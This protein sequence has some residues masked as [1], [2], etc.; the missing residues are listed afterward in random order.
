MP[1]TTSW[2]RPGEPREQLAGVRGVARL[3]EHLAVERDVG[4][5]AQDELAVRTASALRRAFSSAS[6]RGSPLRELLDVRRADLEGH[7]ELLQD[8]PPLGRE[9]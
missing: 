5:G 3:A 8:R 2:R 1:P 9:R 7:A 4:V 6:S